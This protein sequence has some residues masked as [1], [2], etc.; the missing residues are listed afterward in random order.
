MLG[1]FFDSEDGNKI[2]LRNVGGLSTDYAA[3]YPRR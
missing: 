2:F 3:E 1:L